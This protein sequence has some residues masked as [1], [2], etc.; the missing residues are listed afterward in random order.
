MPTGHCD[1][2]MKKGWRFLT[3][4]VRS[5]TWTVL[6]LDRTERRLQEEELRSLRNYLANIIDSMPSALIGVDKEGNVTRWN[7]EAERLTGIARDTAAGQHLT[8]VIPR[9]VVEMERVHASHGNGSGAIRS[10]TH[11]TGKPA[12]SV[13]RM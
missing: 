12:R 13:M 11:V 10:Q 1:G 9:L 6:S 5:P 7:S 3:S 2:Y 8:K 4:R